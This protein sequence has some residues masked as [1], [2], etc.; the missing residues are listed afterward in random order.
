M[1]DNLDFLN[2]HEQEEEIDEYVTTQQKADMLV[3]RFNGIEYAINCV[4]EIIDA[5]EVYGRSYDEIRKLSDEFAYW[6][7]VLSILKNA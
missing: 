2:P 5:F 1:E 4:L 7:E 3:K 6:N